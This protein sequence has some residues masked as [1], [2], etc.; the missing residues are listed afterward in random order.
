MTGNVEGT[1]QQSSAEQVTPQATPQETGKEPQAQP[2]YVT[3][4][5]MGVFANQI[6]EKIKQ[7]DK[8]R[9]KRVEG[10]LGA[11]KDLIT[12]GGV[13]LTPQQE[14]AMREEIGARL[15]QETANPVTS[16]AQ[17]TTQQAADIDPVAEFAKSVFDQV[18][19]TVT[20]NDPEWAA[21]QKVMDENFNNPSPA[22]LARVSAAMV[23]AATT[24]KARTTNN[25][26]SAAARVGGGGSVANSSYDETKSALD[27]LEEAHRK[28]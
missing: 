3:K 7:S 8:D 25:Q 27:Y 16:Q 19:A 2:Q 28:K 22:A 24:K 21:I 23:T 9:S 13:Q 20:K 5:D 17:L 12:K 11:I 14:Q 6:V 4:E 10:E 1:T 15:D 26:E 18:G